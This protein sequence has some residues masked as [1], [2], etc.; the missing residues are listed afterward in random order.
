MQRLL[1]TLWLAPC[2]LRG[3][4]RFFWYKIWTYQ[5]T[6]EDREM[7]MLV[8]KKMPLQSLFTWIVALF[9]LYVSNFYKF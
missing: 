8:L 7:A 9:R 2:V 3:A 6:F 5:K 1:N 4:W